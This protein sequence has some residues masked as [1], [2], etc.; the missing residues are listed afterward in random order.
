MPQRL[1]DAPPQADLQ[2][3]P[4]AGLSGEALREYIS[5]L[6]DDLAGL[7]FQGAHIQQALQVSV[8]CF[9]NI[10]VFIYKAAAVSS[11]VVT[12]AAAP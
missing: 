8:C 2:D 4:A 3:E 11:R 9:D 5:S 6:F 7:G 10:H 12:S 1:G